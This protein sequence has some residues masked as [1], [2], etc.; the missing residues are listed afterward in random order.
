[1]LGMDRVYVIRHKWNDEG[2]SIRQIARDLGVSRNTVLSVRA[3]LRA[4][5]RGT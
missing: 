4:P 3:V 5:G 1:M 2:L